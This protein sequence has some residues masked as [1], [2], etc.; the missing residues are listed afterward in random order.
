MALAWPSLARAQGFLVGHEDLPLLA[1]LV[2]TADSMMVYDV[3]QGRVVEAFAQ[4][5][6]GASKVFKAYG[7]ALPQMGWKAKSPRKFVRKDETL[8]FEVISEG[9]P[10][11]IRIL[12]TSD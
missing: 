12:L 7:D 1:G 4:T 10:T 2:Q 11:V 6:S 5:E 9:H 8:T 3:P